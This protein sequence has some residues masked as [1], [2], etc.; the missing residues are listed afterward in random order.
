MRPQEFPHPYYFE[1]RDDLAQGNSHE[2]IDDMSDIVHNCLL[3]VLARWE[4]MAGFFDDL[5]CEKRALLDP[6]FHDTLLTDDLALSRS[7]R[8]FWAIEFLK[9]LEKSATGNI[10]ETDRFLCYLRDNPPSDSPVPS[11]EFRSRVQKLSSALTKLD[12]LRLKFSQKREEAM[13][14]RDGVSL[15][16]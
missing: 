4:E 8:Y 11:K 13:A 5:L 15:E 14:L 1:Q 7:K 2:M 12:I 6:A 3:A 9:E 16:C 10:R